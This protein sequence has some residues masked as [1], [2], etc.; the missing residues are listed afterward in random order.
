M[1]DQSKCNSVHR[2]WCI[3]KDRILVAWFIVLLLQDTVK[4]TYNR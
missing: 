4:D 1:A 2:P 3:E